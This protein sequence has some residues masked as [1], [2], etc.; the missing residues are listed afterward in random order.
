MRQLALVTLSFEDRDRDMVLETYQAVVVDH[1]QGK[2][3]KEVK[4]AQALGRTLHSDW[5]ELALA[6]TTRT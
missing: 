5:E 4:A 3:V 1:L 6:E 2:G